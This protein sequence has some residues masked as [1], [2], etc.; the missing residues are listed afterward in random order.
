MRTILKKA[1]IS[2]LNRGEKLLNKLIIIL[3]MTTIILVL[4]LIVTGYSNNMYGILNVSEE[5]AT[6]TYNTKTEPFHH[7]STTK[8]KKFTF[9]PPGYYELKYCLREGLVKA[10][11]NGTPAYVIKKYGVGGA[12][13]RV[14]RGTTVKVII[15]VLPLLSTSTHCFSFHFNSRI[16][17]FGIL[18]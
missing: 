15:T 18:M 4:A 5:K 16:I 3:I 6:T 17:S 10:H 12:L 13:F 9:P 7:N 11:F 8:M 14:K 1:N 2:F